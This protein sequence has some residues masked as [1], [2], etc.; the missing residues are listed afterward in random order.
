M[1]DEIRPSVVFRSYELNTKKLDRTLVTLIPSPD[2][3]STTMLEKALLVALLRLNNSKRIF[4]FG[5]FRG[6]TTHLFCVNSESDAE[7]ISIDLPVSFDS[8]NAEAD[9]DRFDLF[10]GNDNDD[11]LRQFRINKMFPEFQH[12]LE[13][14]NKRIRLLESDS[15]DLDPENFA[16]IDFIFIDGGHS[17]EL[18]KNDTIKSFKM[19][20][21]S[22]IIV[23]HDFESSIHTDVTTFLTEFSN[24]NNLRLFHVIGTKLAIYFSP[25][26]LEKFVI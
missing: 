23:W 11:F 17:T 15:R 14:E 18:I 9:L 7:V 4:E 13:D 26:I 12:I 3:G 19:L 8:L 21:D 5:T 6:E 10:S 25:T 24:E 16:P 20:S 22:G 1:F 2:I